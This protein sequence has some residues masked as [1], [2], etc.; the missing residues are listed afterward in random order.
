MFVALYAVCSVISV[1]LSKVYEFVE[2]L[3]I[4]SYCSLNV[5]IGLKNLETMAILLYIWLSNGFIIIV[6]LIIQLLTLLYNW[7]RDSSSHFLTMERNYLFDIN[8]G[9][10]N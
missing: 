9:I 3:N 1:V 5:L 7:K 10:M 8:E 4:M 2:G 6:M